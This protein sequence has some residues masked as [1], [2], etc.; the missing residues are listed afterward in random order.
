MKIGDKIV[1]V[2][3]SP[4]HCR[5]CPGRVDSR[6]ILGNVY[7]VAGFQTYK[8]GGIGVLLLGMKP[9]HH[10]S[11]FGYDINRFRLLS[12]MKNSINKPIN[13]HSIDALR[14]KV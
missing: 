1:C 7:V 13:D 9:D 11:K 4:S 10:V 12:E 2:D 3:A 6:L 8:L 5:C 14:S